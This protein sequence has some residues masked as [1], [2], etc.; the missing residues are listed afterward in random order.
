MDFALPAN[1][2]STDSHGGGRFRLPGIQFAVA[3]LRGQRRAIGEAKRREPIA[4][5]LF[6]PLFQ[7]A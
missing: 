3:D 6:L 5:P 4:M 2:S 7:A 1:P